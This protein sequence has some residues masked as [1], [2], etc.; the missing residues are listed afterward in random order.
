MAV[1][2]ALMK[3]NDWELD[4]HKQSREAR[5]HVQFPT[6]IPSWTV[7]LYTEWGAVPLE[8][9]VCRLQTGFMDIAHMRIWTHWMV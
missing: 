9:L 5:K 7:P 2:T 6:K 3:E 4:G 1:A 8:C